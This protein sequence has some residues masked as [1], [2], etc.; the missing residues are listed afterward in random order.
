[1]IRMCAQTSIL[2]TTFV[3]MSACATDD[4][5]SQATLFDHL[6]GKE[7]IKMVV[8]DFIDAVARDQRIENSKV[9][10]RLGE[11]DIGRLKELVAEQVCMAAG[12]PCQYTGRDM[13]SSHAGL[14]ITN[15]EFDFVVDD[16]IQILDQ[17]RVPDKD[18]Q[19]LL[20]LLA[21]MRADIVQAP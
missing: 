9:S 3:F 11:I 21:P 7:A 16:L 12:G 15:D 2:I 18:Q 4:L 6:G 8:N 17:Y 19:E 5:K 14:D 10:E 13:Q 20:L 1:M